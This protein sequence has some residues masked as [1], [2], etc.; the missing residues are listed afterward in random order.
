ML[1]RA[2]EVWMKDASVYDVSVCLSYAVFSSP[3][4]QAVSDLLRAITSLPGDT[5]LLTLPPGPLLQF[6]CEVA[7]KEISAIWLS[8]AGRLILQLNPPTFSSLKPA[9]STET[10]DLLNRLVPVLIR[11]SLNVLAF[12]NGMVAVNHSS[13]HKCRPSD[14]FSPQNPDIIKALFECMTTVR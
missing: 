1:R 8:Q 2:I 4:L 11:S 5:T 12:Q 3:S 14:S 6:V 9:A 13:Q 10:L 7:D